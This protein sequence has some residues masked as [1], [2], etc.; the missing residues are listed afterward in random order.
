MSK[1][2]IENNN[3]SRCMRGEQP[4]CVSACPFSLD[5]RGF[6]EKMQK[7]SFDAALRAYRNAVVFPQIVARLCPAP[8]QGA[9]VRNASDEGVLLRFLERACV[10]LAKN[11]H[12][13][14]YNLPPKNKRIA[15]VGAGIS[16]LTCALKL[17][18]KKYQV[19][20]FE[21]SAQI[22]GKL[23]D[24]LPSE[25]F[26]SDIE[27]EFQFASYDLHLNTKIVSLDELTSDAIYLATGSQGEAFGLLDGL[28]TDTLATTCPGV[29]L[30]GGLL[31]ETVVEAIEQGMRAAQ[32]IEIFL[33][34]GTVSGGA[35]RAPTRLKT[36]DSLLRPMKAVVPANGISYSGEEARAEAKRCLKCDCDRCWRHCD[37]EQYYQRFPLKLK[38]EVYATFEPDVLSPNGSIRLINSC[39][40]CG[41]CKHVCP[42]DVDMENFFLES[43]RK[44]N[45]LGLMPPPFH[46]FWLRDMDFANGEECY[47]A[48]SPK[49][50]EKSRYAF[51][52]GCQIGASDERYVS[53][54]YRYLL[55][56]Q[57]DTALF[58]S[59]CGA[60]AA[61]A[62]EDEKHRKWTAQL[63][64]E[65]HR[66]G[67]PQL[68]FACPTCKKMFQTY[69]PQISGVSLYD[70]IA[71]WGLPAVKN[72]EGALV[73]VFDPCASRYDPPMQ[74][75]VRLLA[76]KAGYVLEELPA[77]GENARCCSW[78]GQ[79]YP[80]NPQFAE[81]VF[82][83]RTKQ[84]SLPYITY[85]TNCRDIFAKAGK[86]NRHILDI[87]FD[88]NDAWQQPPTISQRRRN[89]INLKRQ[90][91]KMI[92]DEE[93]T[94]NTA[95]EKAI[96]LT[97]P[98]ELLPQ[99]NKDLILEEDVWRTVAHCEKTGQKMLDLAT[100]HLI[101]Y[102]SLGPITYWV[103]YQKQGDGFLLVKA[104][105]HRLRIEEKAK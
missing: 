20:I 21:Q 18:S 6:I 80:A 65:W 103:E 83:D 44:L 1:E 62:G 15:L 68:I 81:K 25:V 40:M 10:E 73:S 88:L 67:R 5:V 33:K 8:C 84:S 79:V 90:L 52:P 42:E 91:L 13:P 24:L 45:Q 41:S 3:I 46:D 101:G 19:E 54:S 29:F 93:M 16:G 95:E 86:E 60:P 2:L 74:Q 26:L 39:N 23:W 96:Q 50:Y 77:H 64:A 99:L 47:L 59:C 51:F 100:G 22:G 30:G 58:L 32:S 57:P 38:D 14:D 72:G 48:R 85:C 61:W 87:L 43:R 71:E 105:S 75:S 53:E 17:A 27:R 4:P 94:N 98:P 9:C 37:L 66:L 70:K 56:H 92:W 55:Q 31:A 49:G 89:R 36:D 28:T 11:P 69:L 104:Y 82:A 78:G 97:I 76:A 35:K 102:L 63:E 34:T 7:G 12:P